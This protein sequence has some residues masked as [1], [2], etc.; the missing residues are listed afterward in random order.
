MK[1]I[2]S[3]LDTA[4]VYGSLKVVSGDEP[5]ANDDDMRQRETC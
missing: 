3:S 5:K 2:T 4:L 1:I